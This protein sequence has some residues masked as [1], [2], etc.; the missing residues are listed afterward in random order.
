M[1]TH[2]DQVPKKQTSPRR[3]YTTSY[4]SQTKTFPLTLHNSASPLKTQTEFAF[5][6]ELRHQR[7]WW[8]TPAVSKLL[9]QQH[10]LRRETPVVKPNPITFVLISC[11]K[12]KRATK[13]PARELY[14]G[15]L[16]KKAVAWAERHDHPWFIISALHGLVTPDQELQP[17]DYPLNQL[18]AREREA[19][20][21]RA[22]GVLDKYASSGSHAVLIMSELYRTHIQTAL[23]EHRITYENPLEGMGIGQ[24]MKWLESE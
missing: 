23:L 7:N 11:S 15:K 22:I 19:W 2:S 21:Q 18:R 20:A 9:Y 4:Q 17:Y 13:A 12:S 14:T 24:Q 6:N 3:R 16:F 1:T 8:A 10:K 5:A